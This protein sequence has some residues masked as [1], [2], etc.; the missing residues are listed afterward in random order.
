MGN[1]RESVPRGTSTDPTNASTQESVSH[2][3]RARACLSCRANKSRC[4]AVRNEDSCH[5]CLKAFRQC[6]MPGPTKP[7]VGTA[8]R[9]GK[10]ERKIE[11]LTNALLSQQQQRRGS[12][13][14][15][16]GDDDRSEG[17]VRSPRRASSQPSGSYDSARYFP[18][19]RI[20]PG[21]GP[22]TS[23]PVFAFNIGSPEFTSVK[24][25]TGLDIVSK[26]TG[27]TL[28][29]HWKANI[30]SLSPAVVL[31]TSSDADTI[32]ARKP[33]LFLAIATVASA[34]VQ[35]CL[36]S[37][38]V[39]VLTRDLA[40]RILVV[41]EKSLEL[42]QAIVAYADNFFP[43]DNARASAFTKYIHCALS[44][45]IYLGLDK[46]RIGDH[47]KDYAEALEWERA[48]LGCYYIASCNAALFGHPLPVV[49]TATLEGQKR[50]LIEGPN[51][52]DNDRH[53]LSLLRI[54]GILNDVSRVFKL[55]HE[56]TPISF[57]EGISQLQLETFR[58][59]IEM[60]PGARDNSKFV[61]L[62]EFL[63]P[64]VTIYT[65]D[66]AVRSY[67]LTCIGRKAQDMSLSPAHLE[68][69]YL[70]L[71]SCHGVLSM[72]LSYPV[73]LARCLPNLYLVWTVYAATILIRL[74]HFQKTALQSPIAGM[75]ETTTEQF[76]DA[77]ITRLGEISAEGYCLSAR[78]FHS[79]FKKLKL[80]E[81]HR[82][83]RHGEEHSKND[84]LVAN[85]G[86]K[87]A[88]SKSMMYNTQN[89][90][91]W[92]DAQLLREIKEVGF[93]PTNQFE[94]QL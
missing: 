47:I 5:A 33:L 73:Q 91:T 94:T 37:P 1:R 79:V 17:D 61:R 23:A 38:L 4:I 24:H 50:M 40:E 83:A 86:I 54:Q 16:T 29:N 81:V 65:H 20:F 12:I 7:R 93:S 30:S 72:Y 85:S 67:N 63:I 84:L 28:F 71:Q 60:I 34:S 89:T 87:S 13:D 76:L 69:L 25:V 90:T 42:V 9:V 44:I 57:N 62:I 46:G 8:Q 92:K 15:E 22:Q 77:L 74:G 88:P 32:R 64:A 3:K 56:T 52:T 59:R 35:P 10:L 75:L 6:V 11:R 55:N 49:T 58:Q 80:W 36:Q 14:S 70:C 41:G 43:A 53:M 45:C 78:E 48:W 66:V 26:S 19:D 18:S 2:R 39:K 82:K 51:A 21:E 68:A 31:A 27:T